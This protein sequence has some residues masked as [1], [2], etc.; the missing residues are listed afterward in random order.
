MSPDGQAASCVADR[1][2][3]DIPADA[4]LT[5]AIDRLVD[6]ELFGLA[7]QRLLRQT[8]TLLV[9][10]ERLT[11]VTARAVQ[12][13]DSRELFTAD[14]AGSTQ[15]WLRQQ[16]CG[17]RGQLHRARRLH[18][19]PR[20]AAGLAAGTISAAA[21]DTVG[22]ALESVPEQTAED[23]LLGVLKNA[24][25]DLLATWVG[26]RLLNDA[27]SAEQ[28]AR[29]QRID[30][31]VEQCVADSFTA[32]AG[33][34][35]PAFV[36]LAEALA[37]AV[38]ASQLQVLVDALAPE[39]LT[40]DEADCWD[41]R[42][43]HLRK[44]KLRPG[45]KLNAHLTDE[46]GQRLY[47]ALHARARTTRQPADDS[48]SG[49]GT[50]DQGTGDQGTGEARTDEAGTD[51]EGRSGADGGAAPPAG[52]WGEVGPG[53]P[54]EHQGDPFTALGS[55]GWELPVEG[56][57]V[58]TDAQVLHDTLQDLLDDAAAARAPGDPRPA[59]LTIIATVDALEGRAGVL[60]GTLSTR[61]GPVS[62]PT[63]TV[64]RLGCHSRLTAIL[65]DA[66]RHPIGVSGTHRNA[67]EKERRALRAKWGVFCAINGC[68][69]LGTVPHHVTPY[70][71]SGQ[72][73]LEDLLLICTMNHHD[74]HE[75]G[76]TL[77]LR[78]GRLIDPDGWV[79][80]PTA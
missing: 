77:R 50:A 41:Q 52:D 75:G 16:V 22:K 35:E 11:A 42:G 54:V 12:E 40:D 34:L 26:G 31:V 6:Q 59:D 74:I 68:G 73:R 10:G 72:T 67:T 7:D 3:A 70:W 45:W 61:D 19:H 55:G 44:H 39:Q 2:P 58:R 9:Q 60:P 79:T 17:D 13:F 47:D 46:T 24:V 4:L 51:G 36:L 63:E 8:A 30:T 56:E 29:Q 62:L 23:Q 43:L 15:G 71:R 66:H 78:D 25:P 57:P 27:L 1:V 32:P 5:L 49:Q 28:L 37:P 20:L 80:E 21:A 65:L 53:L 69:N 64:R 76:R 18:T 38:L 33:R 14:G 48:T